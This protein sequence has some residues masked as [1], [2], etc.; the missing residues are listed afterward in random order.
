[1]EIRHLM[2]DYCYV[3]RS[4]T[5][6]GI[7]LKRISEILDFLEAGY[8]GSKAYIEALNVAS[9]AKDILNAAISRKESVGAH[10]R[11]DC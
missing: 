9:I 6:L 5:G 8:A 4:E 7:A 3:I 10:Y 1:M 2:H 11:E